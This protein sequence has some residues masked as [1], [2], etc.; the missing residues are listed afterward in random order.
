MT[1]RNRQT[2]LVGV[3]SK[4]KNLQIKYLYYFLFGKDNL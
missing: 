3:T 2:D 1:E 4:K